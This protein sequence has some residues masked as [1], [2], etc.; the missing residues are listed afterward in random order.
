[1]ALNCYMMN[2]F[3]FKNEK[4]MD[5]VTKIK[6]EDIHDFHVKNEKYDTEKFVINA[7]WGIKTYLLKENLDDIEIHKLKSKG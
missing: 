5:L 6:S 4:I 1:M 2:Q 7:A 3:T